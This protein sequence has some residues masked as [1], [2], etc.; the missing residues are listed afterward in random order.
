MT[1]SLFFLNL[2][3]L[4][5]GGILNIRVGE[6]IRVRSVIPDA[7]SRRNIVT[8]KQTTNILKFLPSAKI[9]SHMETEIKDM[10]DTDKMLLEDC[11]EVL[12]SPVQLTEI[13]DRVYQCENNKKKFK[14]FRLQDLFLNFDS[15]PEEVRERNCFR[16]SF[17]VYRF[18]PSDARD[19]V[20]A[21]CPKCNE[22]ISCKD[23]DADGKAECLTCKVPTKLIY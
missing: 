7:T 17:C 23:L 20:V 14:P 13:T 2:P 10:T 5:F 21:A 16:V 19:I 15:F 22:T 18:D 12:M 3:K 8:H 4:R 1:S 6:I 11:S 9:V